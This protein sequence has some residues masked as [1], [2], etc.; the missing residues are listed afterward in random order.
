VQEKWLKPELGSVSVNTPASS[1]RLESGPDR[2]Y[3]ES[4]SGVLTMPGTDQEA[5]LEALETRIAYQDHTIEE[6]N[7]TITEQWRAI[8]LLTKKL[9]MMEEQVRTGSYIADPATDKPPPH[10]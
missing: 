6:L 8:D 3:C 9:A 4:K 10:Y 7:A 2:A 5:R 1:K